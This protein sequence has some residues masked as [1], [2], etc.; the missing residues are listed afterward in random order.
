MCLHSLVRCEIIAKVYQP[1]EPDI[2]NEN[3]NSDLLTPQQRAVKSCL[4]SVL[5]RSSLETIMN[6]KLLAP[7]DFICKDWDFSAHFETVSL[8]LRSCAP[9]ASVAL[10]RIKLPV[11]HASAENINQLRASPTCEI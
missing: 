4:A 9:R 11:N 1:L 6:I 8:W 7:I 10:L 5:A 2:F 3:K